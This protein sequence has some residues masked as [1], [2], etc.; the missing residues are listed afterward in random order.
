MC[1]S[2]L[3]SDI[4]RILAEISSFV[5]LNMIFEENNCMNVYNLRFSS[6]IKAHSYI[7]N[8]LWL[9]YLMKKKYEFECF[10]IGKNDFLAI[11][12]KQELI[13]QNDSHLLIHRNYC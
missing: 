5:D 1:N 2:V 12:Q 3:N 13:E 6:L 9:K 11:S 10:H 8:D 7:T 4:D